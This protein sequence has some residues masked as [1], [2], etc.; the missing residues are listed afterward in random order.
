MLNAL[1]AE[2]GMP[3]S[4]SCSGIIIKLPCMVDCDEGPTALSALDA[5]LSAVFEHSVLHS[6]YKGCGWSGFYWACWS[7]HRKKTMS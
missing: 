6:S 2:S 3:V 5:H 1:P 4:V 7:A